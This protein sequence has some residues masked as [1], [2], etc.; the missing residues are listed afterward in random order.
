MITWSDQL[1][2]HSS[3]MDTHTVLVLSRGNLHLTHA[4]SVKFLALQIIRPDR[5]LVVL[6]IAF[7]M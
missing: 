1:S 3:I 4:V 7:Y 5:L 6:Q 2:V